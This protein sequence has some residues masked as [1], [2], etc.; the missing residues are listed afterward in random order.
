MVRGFTRAVS[1]VYGAVATARRRW[2]AGDPSRR[3]RLA[4]P[5]ISVGN[6]RVGGSGKTPV[7]AH[8]A[9]MLLM[10]GERPAIL[11][12]GY[13]RER[14]PDG[15]TVVSDGTA[16]RSGLADSGDEPLL[17]ARAL[18]GV[19]VL[20]CADRSIAGRLAEQ[21]FGATVHLLDDGFQHVQLSRDV[22][23]LLVSTDDLAD[24]VLPAGRL[25]EPIRN[26]AAADAVLVSDG[27]PQTAVSIGHRLGVGHAWSVRRSVGEPNALTP[28]A[29]TRDLPV[30]AFAGIARPE[31]FFADLRSAG[32]TVVGTRSYRDHY[33]FRQ[34]DIASLIEEA[35]AGGAVAALTTE[36]D[37]VRLEM[38][39][40]SAFAFGAVPLRVSIEPAETFASW[41][42]ARLARAR[43]QEEPAVPQPGEAASR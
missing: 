28:L 8:L 34:Q 14:Q 10:H 3:R 16:V 40:L 27:D 42:T 7:V 39:D 38:L 4:R 41:L 12:R 43:Q 2:Y 23:L 17:L 19:P 18:P 25:R 37:A 29:F 30:F 24:Q 11:S 1:A 36:K 35:R 33:R 13:A 31:R 22:D 32:W 6:L 26:A 9:E 20:V 21:Q 15:V 5:V